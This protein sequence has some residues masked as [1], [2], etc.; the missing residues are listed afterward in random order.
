M[1]LCKAGPVSLQG[2]KRAEKRLD[3]DGN[4]EDGFGEGKRKLKLPV[5]FGGFVCPGPD[6]SART[7]N[8]KAPTGLMPAREGR[9]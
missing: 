8:C 2:S 7:R 3:Q 4:F 9:H 1:M 5:H 6:L